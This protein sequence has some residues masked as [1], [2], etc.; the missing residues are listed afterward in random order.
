MG[1]RFSLDPLLGSRSPFMV[2]F[3]AIAAAVFCGR[4]LGGLVATSLSLLA[5]NY[6]FSDPRYS[7]GTQGGA[8][9]WIVALFL[10]GAG[11]IICLGESMHRARDRSEA[12]RAKAERTEQE[13]RHVVETANEGIWLLD[14]QGRVEMVNP[15][16]CEML[17]YT[18]EEMKGQHKWDFVF[19]EDQAR[20]RA[21]FERRR[22]GISEQADLRFRS[23]PGQPVWIL[24]AA[25]A[26]F[27]EQG[28]FKGALDMFTDITDRKK[29]E[30]ELEAKILERTGRLEEI[31]QELEVFSYSIAHD[32]RAPL[33][34]MQGISRAVLEDYE[35]LL[36]EQ[37]R[38]YLKRIADSARLMDRQI[39]NVLEYNRLLGDELPVHAVELTGVLAEIL[40]YP[41]L[42]AHRDCIRVDT[43]L[44]LVLA[45][46][47]ALKQVLANLLS[48]AVKFVVSGQKPQVR[49]RAERNGEFVVLFI[50]DNGIGISSKGQQKIFRLF[51][52]LQ[53]TEIY[54]GTGIGL[55]IVKKAVER[56]GGQVGVKSEPGKGSEF[57]ITLPVAKEGALAADTPNEATA[58]QTLAAVMG[59]AAGHQPPN[60]QQ[61]QTVPF[62][63]AGK[64]AA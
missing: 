49:L 35:H 9:S 59:D 13:A 27:D 34:A 32:L 61:L 15:R 25:K 46:R 8:E 60:G 51:Q 36:P 1:L 16:L 63:P 58:H 47:A 62:W 22:K 29:L 42:E 3:P 45:N 4:A 64:A 53:P 43:E 10:L 23:K 50:K 21:L 12:L 55:A 52:R 7:L 28:R 37:G 31:I 54:E 41:D 18:A 6:F 57:W 2:F 26:R 33:R 48:N 19:P 20:A 17:G 24:M 14:E 30:L 11:V 39:L 56:M 40:A 5:A 38:D 44:P